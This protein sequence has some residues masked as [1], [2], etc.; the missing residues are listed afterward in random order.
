MDVGGGGEIQTVSWYGRNWPRAKS[1]QVSVL[2]IHG[3]KYPRSVATFWVNSGVSGACVQL[4]TS[5]PHDNNGNPVPKH[6]HTGS[7]SCSNNINPLM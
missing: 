1:M 4:Y 2:L 5:K 3:L 7:A 6:C